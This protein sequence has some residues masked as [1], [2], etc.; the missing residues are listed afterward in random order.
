[1][2]FRIDGWPHCV[3]RKTGSPAQ[4]EILRPRK[5]TK[6]ADLLTADEMRVMMPS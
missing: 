2:T 1:M 5:L 4:P 6:A 3:E